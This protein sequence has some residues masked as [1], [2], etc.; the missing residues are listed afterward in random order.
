MEKIIK[1]INQT[2]EESMGETRL[3][4]YMEDIWAILTKTRV[5]S[6]QMNMYIVV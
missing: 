1:A 5:K 6:T 2:R 3:S 4:I